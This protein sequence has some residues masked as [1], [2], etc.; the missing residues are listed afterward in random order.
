[1]SLLDSHPFPLLEDSLEGF[2]P[3]TLLSCIQDPG[4]G[5][6]FMF[7]LRFK[8]RSEL[9]IC[10]WDSDAMS[11]IE[12]PQTFEMWGKPEEYFREL[13]PSLFERAAL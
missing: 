4:Y 10:I 6:V 9:G 13:Y 1:M 11:F 7:L 5:H 2:E 12:E 8:R 3:L